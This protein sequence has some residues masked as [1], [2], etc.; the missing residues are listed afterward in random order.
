[1]NSAIAAFTPT[2]WTGFNQIVQERKVGLGQHSEPIRPKMSI[3]SKNRFEPQM[4]DDLK[5]DAIDQAELPF[6]RRQ[7]CGHTN[8]RRW[9][10]LMRPFLLQHHEDGLEQDA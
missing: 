5:T 3:E 9:I 6:R 10:G 1:M 4:A 7:E 2:T 8:R